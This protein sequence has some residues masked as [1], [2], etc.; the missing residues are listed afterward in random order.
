MCM[1]DIAPQDLESY[2]PAISPVGVLQRRLLSSVGA[3]YSGA[4]FKAFT[5]FVITHFRS[6][7]YITAQ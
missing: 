7:Y 3:L 6:S 5:R 4:F 1:R 2:E